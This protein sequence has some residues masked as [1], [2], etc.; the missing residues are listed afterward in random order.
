[1]FA[2]NKVKHRKDYFPFFFYFLFRS[3]SLPYPLPLPGPVI[4]HAIWFCGSHFPLLWYAPI[5]PL[6]ESP[7]NRTFKI[8]WRPPELRRVLRGLPSIALFIVLEQSIL[9]SF[10]HSKLS[11]KVVFHQ[12]GQLYKVTELSCVT[13]SS[14]YT[15]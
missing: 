5:H 2:N 7:L 3:L 15:S 6:P 14:I 11:N 13:I 1:M 8:R 12:P 9:L 10:L 4:P